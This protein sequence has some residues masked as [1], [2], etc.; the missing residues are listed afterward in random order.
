[1]VYFAIRQLGRELSSP[2]EKTD[3]VCFTSVFSTSLQ[4]DLLQD[5]N[6]HYIFL[7]S[8]QI[9]VVDPK[10]TQFLAVYLNNETV[11]A[12]PDGGFRCPNT[13]ELSSVKY[14]ICNII[15]EYL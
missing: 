9:S 6:D 8:E 2:H 10:G 1:M 13:N 14:R 7:P 11:L 4:Q 5:L 12:C 15:G 3:L